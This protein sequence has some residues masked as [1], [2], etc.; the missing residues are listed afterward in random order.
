MTVPDIC[1]CIAILIPGTGPSGD[2]GRSHTFVIVKDDISNGDLYIVPICS[3]RQ[4]SRQTCVIIE[5]NSGWAEIRKKSFVAYDLA[6]KVPRQNTIKCING[7]G[8]TLLG[9]VP[10]HI[11]SKIFD[12][13]KTSPDV[14]PWFRNAVIDPPKPRILASQ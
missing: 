8:I 4:R 13:I 9:P 7:S 10:A 6:K 2:D 14:E 11:Y 3:V 12:G 1:A 5:A